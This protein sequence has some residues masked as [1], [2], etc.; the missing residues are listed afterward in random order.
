[1]AMPVLMKRPAPCDNLLQTCKPDP[2]S[3]RSRDG[4]HLSVPP[5][6]RGIN[7]ST[8][9]RPFRRNG[10]IGR[11]ALYADLYDISACKVYPR[12][13]LPSTAVSSYLTFSP[14]P[15]AVAGVVIFCGTFCY[16]V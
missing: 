5:V 2:V 12:K 14:F 16:R 7:L 11:A 8:H 10:T 9:P 4:Y 15:P 1:M 6:T 13:M 3:R